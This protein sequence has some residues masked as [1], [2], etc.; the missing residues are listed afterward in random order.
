MNKKLNKMVAKLK[1]DF[2]WLGH[3]KYIMKKFIMM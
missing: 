1:I 3:K 2:L